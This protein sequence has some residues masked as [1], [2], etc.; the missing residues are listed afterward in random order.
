MSQAQ[1]TAH[2][3][4]LVDTFA[5]LVASAKAGDTLEA[6][7]AGLDTLSQKLLL[8]CSNLLDLTAELKHAATL[9]A[10]F[11]LQEPPAS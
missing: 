4:T 7:R 11:Q 6:D 10:A 1:L 5:R 8:A 2:I 3:D 9:A